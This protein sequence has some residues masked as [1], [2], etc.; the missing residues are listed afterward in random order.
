MFSSCDQQARQLNCSLNRLVTLNFYGL[1]THRRILHDESVRYG[2]LARYCIFGLTY[3][4]V[5]NIPCSNAGL[6]CFATE[7]GESN[8]SLIVSRAIFGYH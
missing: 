6:A 4:K 7:L 8:G 3:L 5:L 1:T 2:L